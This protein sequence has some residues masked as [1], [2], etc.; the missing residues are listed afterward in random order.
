MYER[1][2]DNYFASFFGARVARK[3]A[4]KRAVLRLLLVVV[5]AAMLGAVVVVDAKMQ[6]SRLVR[7]G[8][9]SWDFLGKFCFSKGECYMYWRC[10]AAV[11]A[12][13]LIGSIHYKVLET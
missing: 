2:I 12:R 9:D 3:M 5:L 4:G 8:T 13:Y 6:H 11:F 1:L 10:W 7:K